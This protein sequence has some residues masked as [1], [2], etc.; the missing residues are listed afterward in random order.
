MI[1]EKCSTNASSSPHHLSATKGHVMTY[2]RKKQHILLEYIWIN[3]LFL[4]YPHQNWQLILP[5][6][7]NSCLN[8]MKSIHKLNLGFEI[9]RCFVFWDGWKGWSR[10]VRSRVTSGITRHWHP[11]CLVTGHF[12]S[13]STEKRRHAPEFL[14]HIHITI[15]HTLFST[16]DL[17]KLWEIKYL[18]HSNNH[19]YLPGKIGSR[20]DVAW[21]RPCHV[22]C[23]IGI[24][25]II[26]RLTKHIE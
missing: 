4:S 21:K 11:C 14:W 2:E 24:H 12:V 15:L 22:S 19:I 26:S 25:R 23:K 10:W 16:L 13:I 20:I 18:K 8:K 9:S 3:L 6:Y 1:N 5:P 7:Q 17:Y